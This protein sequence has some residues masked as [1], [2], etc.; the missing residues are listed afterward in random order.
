MSHCSVLFCSI[1]S[2]L[3]SASMH[4]DGGDEVLTLVW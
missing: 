4:A 1:C 3:G 2:A